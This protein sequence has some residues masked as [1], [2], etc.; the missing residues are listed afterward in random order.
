MADVSNTTVEGKR[1]RLLQADATMASLQ[2]DIEKRRD[3]NLTM[4]QN[5][6]DVLR[7]CVDERMRVLQ[8]AVQEEA[9]GTLDRI[10]ERREQCKSL[11]SKL[12]H[13][14]SGESDFTEE[15]ITEINKQYTEL[16]S[17]V[18]ERIYKKSEVSMPQLDTLTSS[19]EA[20]GQVQSVTIPKIEPTKCSVEGVSVPK[21]KNSSFTM[22][23]RDDEGRVLGGC[24]DS[25][26]VTV[27][28]SGK[29]KVQLQDTA[30]IE[31]QPGTGI[32]LVKYSPKQ[33]ATYQVIYDYIEVSVVV[34]VVYT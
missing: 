1:S 4:I 27:M 12:E 30:I 25:I 24:A 33:I 15:Q 28:A 20:V 18:V 17:D 10:R 26:K 32:Y 21:G 7:K 22:T 3:N 6:F 5:T 31:E 11:C 14:M 9:S 8:Q 29:G 23:L 34:Y 2:D 16:H 19:I 13:M